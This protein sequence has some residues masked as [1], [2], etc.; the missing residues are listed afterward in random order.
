[1][2]LF[3]K[4]SEKMPKLKEFA[5]GLSMLAAIFIAEAVRV[6]GG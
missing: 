5:L 2:L 1:M 6:M 4:A 3:L